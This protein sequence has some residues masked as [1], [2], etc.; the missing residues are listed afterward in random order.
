MKTIA[1]IGSINMDLSASAERIPRPGE[2]ILASS[3]IY[4]PGGKGANQAVAA[5]RLGA[6]VTFFGCVGNDAFGPGMVRNIASEG[7][8]TDE[9]EILPGTP[10]GLAMITVA[11]GDNAITVVPGANACV[12]KDYI[13]RHFARILEN[14]IL[15]I[16]AEI[17]HETVEYLIRK[18]R[19]EEAALAAQT[20]SSAGAASDA[21]AAS[22]PRCIIF[23]PAP[24]YPLGEDLIRLVDYLTPNEHEARIV[25]SD[26]VTPAEDLVRRFQGRLIIT[27]GSR[28]VLCCT[29][30][31][32]AGGSLQVRQI[33]SFPVEVVDTTGAGDT[34]N[35][36]LAYALASDLPFTDSLRFAN[37]A[38]AFSCTKKGAQSGMPTLD[39]VERLLLDT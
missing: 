2:T 23:N 36:A 25:L 21:A 9:I 27:C 20:A 5:A 15:L 24:A 10:S 33:P 16:V 39:M 18:V 7:I 26:E 12:T 35:G 8:V 4:L 13:D 31:D 19:T 14:D 6:K 32:Q 11:E 29:E 1:V 17:P 34:F 30:D 28:G 22:G 3:L 38:A 37:A